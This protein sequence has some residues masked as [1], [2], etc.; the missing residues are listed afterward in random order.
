MKNIFPDPELPFYENVSKKY[1]HVT[2][3]YFSHPT[4]SFKDF[5]IDSKKGEASLDV[6]LGEYFDFINTCMP[7]QY[8]T[9]YEH[10]FKNRKKP[11]WKSLRTKYRIFDTD[12][13]FV[14][15]GISCFTIIT[16]INNKETKFLLHRRSESVSTSANQLH[17]VPSG[18]YQPSRGSEN[19]EYE[20]IK[21]I[22]P[23]ENLLSTVV[24]EFVEEIYGKEE[25]NELHNVN[26]LNR[27]KN[28]FD[29]TY[30]IGAGFYPLDTHVDIF[31]I[32]IIDA[33]DVIAY[34][35]KEKTVKKVDGYTVEEINK[36]INAN[37]EGKIGLYSF[38]KDEIEEYLK[39]HNA[40]PSLRT[41][42]KYISDNFDNINKLCQ[43]K[44]RKL[45]NQ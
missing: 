42:F 21:L 13:R 37:H 11:S 22:K 8:E 38:T 15:I 33:F 12:N 43:K 23:Q 35:S 10:I 16:N 30:L 28:M 32:S 44:K 6:Y 4:F 39:V 2:P 1:L 45:L 7:F 25:F 14:S 41:L 17:V 18:G 29:D 5:R 26:K 24:R 34:N 40:T 20:N 9:V 3:K 27:Y 31:A 36:V 19:K